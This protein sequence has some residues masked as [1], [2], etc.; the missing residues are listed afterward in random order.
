[1]FTSN[2]FVSFLSTQISSSP[3]RDTKQMAASV[4]QTTGSTPKLA[5][6][7]ESYLPALMQALAYYIELI[8]YEPLH[9]TTI[10][11]PFTV[12]T[13]P[14]ILADISSPDST[15]PKSTTQNVPSTTWWSPPPTI[16]QRPPTTSTEQPVTQSKPPSIPSTTTARPT[17]VPIWFGKKFHS[18]FSSVNLFIF[19]VIDGFIWSFQGQFIHTKSSNSNDNNNAETKTTANNTSTIGQYNNTIVVAP[20]NDTVP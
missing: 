6:L 2:V 8:Q 13:T 15:T 1:M 19:W 18:T 9:T 20:R 12:S 4:S 11:P 14:L 10:E 17:Q 5:R 7:T 16:T 3:Q